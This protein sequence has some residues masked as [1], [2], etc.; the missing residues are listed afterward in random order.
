MNYVSTRGGA[1]KLGFEA[2]MLTGLARDGGLY[3]PESWPVMSHAE[4]AA[5]AGLPYEEAAFRV[6]WHFLGGA[7]GFIYAIEKTKIETRRFAKNQRTWLRRL[8]TTPGSLWINAAALPDDRWPDL[9]LDRLLGPATLEGPENPHA[10]NPVEG[11]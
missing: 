1:P 8:R 9:V 4:I 11:L 6:M 10:S 7:F 2:A 5:L 3:V